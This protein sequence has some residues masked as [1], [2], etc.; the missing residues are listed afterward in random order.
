MTTEEPA[1]T[2]TPGKSMAGRGET[3]TT[4]ARASGRALACKALSEAGGCRPRAG[5]VD[6]A[7]GAACAGCAQDQ[8][9]RWVTLSG[10]S[11]AGNAWGGCG[12]ECAGAGVSRQRRA[13]HGSGSGRGD[14]GGK[15]VQT[16]QREGWNRD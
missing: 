5:M 14:A 2:E 8:G 15:G 13:D 16:G 10:I 9:E 1:A 4:A 12:Q 11:A 3:S 7:S 6:R